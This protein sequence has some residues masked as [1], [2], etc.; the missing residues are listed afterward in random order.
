VISAVGPIEMSQRKRAVLARSAVVLWTRERLDGRAQPDHWLAGDYEDIADHVVDVERFCTSDQEPERAIARHILDLLV[1][2]DLRGSVRV[3]KGASSLADGR[4]RAD[5]EV[6]LTELD[7]KLRPHLE[8]I[9]DHIVDIEPFPPDD[10]L[11]RAL[12]RHI[13]RL[14]APDDARPADPA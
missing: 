10:D 1:R 4:D 5:L 9:A 12:V 7:Q 14:V 3:Q 6:A 2:G 13:A 11:A 8:D